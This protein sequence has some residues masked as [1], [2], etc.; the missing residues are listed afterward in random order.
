MSDPAA[1]RQPK[2]WP[3]LAISVLVILLV[4]FLVVKLRRKD[5]G[6]VVVKNP[7]L[8]VEVAKPGDPLKPVDPVKPADPLKPSDPV[9]PGDPSSEF[10]LKTK[11]LKA[12][13]EAK[14]WDDAAAA[15]EAARKL[16]ADAK[17]LKEAE[18]AI[19]E[20]RKKEEAERQEA[21]RKLALKQKQDRDW[22]VVKERL[23][24]DREKNTWDSAIAALEKFAKE[25]A[26]AEKDTDYVNTLNSMRRLQAEGE[27]YF[28][29][30]MGEAQK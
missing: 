11:Q 12:A 13:I 1:P 24:K 5:E 15:V 3:L 25:Y 8:P 22:A 30:D 28:K 14:R 21:A 10:E 9:K 26:D 20:G 2:G 29:R 27:K 4:G 16:R 17:E 6:P 23:E 19:A 18:E 7:P